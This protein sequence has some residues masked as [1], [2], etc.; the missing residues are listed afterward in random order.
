MHSLA[1]GRRSG[2]WH[3]APRTSPPGGRYTPRGGAGAPRRPDKPGP[4]ASAR[5]TPPTP[6]SY[7]RSPRWVPI[8]AGVLCALGLAVIALNYLGVFP[9]SPA[10]S[11]LF[12]GLGGLVAGL[13]LATRWS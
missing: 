8:T 13:L 1:P 11:Y 9:S 12:G 7:Y 3:A 10:N 2:P 5:Y 4:Q 6:D